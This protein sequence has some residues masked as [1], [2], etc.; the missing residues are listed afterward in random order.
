[1]NYINDYL[2][3]SN[4]SEILNECVDFIKFV[5][6][7]ININDCLGIGSLSSTDL[8]IIKEGNYYELDNLIN[9]NR[10]LNDKLNDIV[11]V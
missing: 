2:E 11:L 10:K 9:E 8:T 6:R 3:L 5:E 7:R 1:M 4:D